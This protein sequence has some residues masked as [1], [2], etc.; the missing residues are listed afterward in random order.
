MKV[1]DRLLAKYSSNAIQ[2]AKA[3]AQRGQTAPS[4]DLRET[5]A[6]MLHGEAQVAGFRANTTLSW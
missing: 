1:F 2:T 4:S 6:S 5:P 3:Q